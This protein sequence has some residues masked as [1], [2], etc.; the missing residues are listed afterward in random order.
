MA[1]QGADRLDAG[2]V[3]IELRQVAQAGPASV[4]VHDDRDVPRQLVG[5]EQRGLTGRERRGGRDADAGAGFGIGRRA[6][7]RWRRVGRSG[8]V[9]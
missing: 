9:G 2:S 5:R 1:E 6:V 4:A 3:A 7:R 8:E